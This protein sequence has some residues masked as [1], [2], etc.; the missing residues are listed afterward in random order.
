MRIALIASG[1]LATASILSG[2]S[3]VTACG[4][5]ERHANL[6]YPSN[7]HYSNLGDTLSALLSRTPAGTAGSQDLEKLWE[8][9]SLSMSW[10]LG[11]M[12]AQSERIS[13]EAASNA[14]EVF[15]EHSADAIFVLAPMSLMGAQHRRLIALRSLAGPLRS[16]EEEVA[17]HYACDAAWEYMAIKQD[18]SYFSL[19]GVDIHDAVRLRQLA[20]IVAE[21]RRLVHGRHRPQMEVIAG[22]VSRHPQ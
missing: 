5:M 12:I 7:Q 13:D 19:G 1:L 18:S 4:S 16:S 21:A 6:S 11:G 8:H 3:V 9:D 17:F 20:S 10:S 15:R 22:L 2:Q 14:A